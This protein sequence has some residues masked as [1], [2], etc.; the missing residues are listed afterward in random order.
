MIDFNNVLIGL[1]IIIVTIVGCVLL[2]SHFAYKRG[3]LSGVELGIEKGK[4]EGI[5]IGREQILNENLIR[6]NML[7]DDEIKHHDEV[8][9][10]I[11]QLAD[12][13]QEVH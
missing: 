8:T 3:K 9:K 11:G 7:L 5:A 1:S 10:F 12:E 4:V 13:R 2:V 6:S